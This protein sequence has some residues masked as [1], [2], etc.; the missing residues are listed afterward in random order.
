MISQVTLNEKCQERINWHFLPPNMNLFNRRKISLGWFKRATKTRTRL[1]AIG[2][3]RS[4][5]MIQSFR[6]RPHVVRFE[7]PS[8][9]TTVMKKFAI[10]RRM[11]PSLCW[12]LVEDLPTHGTYFEFTANSM[13]IDVCFFGVPNWWI[14]LYSLE[15]LCLAGFMICHLIIQQK[16]KKLLLHSRFDVLSIGNPNRNTCFWHQSTRPRE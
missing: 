12:S 7:N 15:N 1:F 10:T 14:E 5:R 6:R 13:N 11:K 3:G 16:I 2:R 4:P 9:M 8:Q